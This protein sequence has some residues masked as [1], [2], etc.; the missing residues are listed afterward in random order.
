LIRAGHPGPSLAITAMIVLLG[1]AGRPGVETLVVFAGAVLAGELS[2]GWSNDVFDARAD[3]AAGRTDKPIV[4]GLISRRAVAVAAMSAL[5]VGAVGSFF[6]SMPTGVIN[7]VMMAAGWAYN[8]GLKATLLSGLMYVV[9]FG[10]I[11]AFAASVSPAHPRPPPWTTTA[12]ALLGLGGHFAN[13]LPD[14]AADRAS[15]VRGLPQ[16]IAAGRGGGLAVRI[17]A[18][19]LLLGA[20]T[21]I[22]LAP[23]GAPRWWHLAGLAAAG[24]LAVIGAV[25]A[26]R[27]PF[28][29]A[30]AIAGLDVVLFLSRGAAAI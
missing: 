10:L 17:V 24:A 8:A 27:V 15:G 4:M 2:I 11:P 19:T 20:S 5:L 25:G 9:G 7:L 18:L 29:A 22:V 30:I 21:L 3:A 6:I 28:I 1:T 26:G 13:V 14:L 16:R 23:A 12:A